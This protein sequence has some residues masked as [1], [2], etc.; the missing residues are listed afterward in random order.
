MDQPKRTP[1]ASGFDLTALL[2]GDL[3][4][5]SAAAVVD[6]PVRDEPSPLGGTTLE[7][8]EACPDASG[9][10]APCIEGTGHTLASH[11]SDVL[12]GS[13]PPAEVDSP[14]D[15][16]QLNAA[17]LQ[18][19][20]QELEDDALDT[21][22]DPDEVEP[23][24]FEIEELV[25][26]LDADDGDQQD[27]EDGLSALVAQLDERPLSVGQLTE[28]LER[29]VLPALRAAAVK[30]GYLTLG[31][32]A[33][34]VVALQASEIH[35]AQVREMVVRLGVPVVP[36]RSHQNVRNLPLAAMHEA[37]RRFGDL[38]QGTP[39]ESLVIARLGYAKVRL[40]EGTRA[41]LMQAWLGHCLSRVEERQHAEAVASEVAR[42]G[43]DFGRW[44]AEAVASREALILDN[45]WSVARIARKYVGRGIEIDDLL[46]FG[47]L[48]LMRAVEKNNPTHGY[49]FVT[50][51]SSWIWQRITREIA[52][53]G[54][55]IRL[56]VHVEEDRKAVEEAFDA[57]Y[58]QL[59][60]PPSI[61]RVAEACGVKQERV[62]ALLVTS[63]P[64][65]L[66]RPG[67]LARIEHRLALAA[68]DIQVDTW[69]RQLAE[70]V[71]QALSS[72]G[73][74]ERKVLE[75][76]FG[77]DIGRDRT[78]EEVGREFGVTRERI[79]QIEA[80]ALRKLHH[81]SRN[82]SLRDYIDLYERPATQQRVGR[83][84][85]PEPTIAALKAALVD[86][87][88]AE[89]E[90]LADVLGLDGRRRRRLKAVC[91]LH[92]VLPEEVDRLQR[93]LRRKVQGVATSS[94]PPAAGTADQGIQKAHAAVT[95]GGR[96]GHR[97]SAAA[98][99]SPPARQGR[100]ETHVQDD[101]VPTD[102]GDLARCSKPDLR[103]R[104][105]IPPAAKVSSDGSAEE[106]SPAPDDTSGLRSLMAKFNPSDAVLADALFGVTTG[107][108]MPAEEV[109]REFGATFAQVRDIEVAAQ[110]LLGAGAVRAR[111][112][113]GAASSSTPTP[114]PPMPT[115]PESTSISTSEPVDAMGAAG[116]LSVEG[117]GEAAEHEGAES[118]DAEPLPAGPD[119]SQGE[120]GS[121]LVSESAMEVIDER[122]APRTLSSAEVWPLVQRFHDR[123]ERQIVEFLFGLLSGKPLTP[124]ATARTLQVPQATVDRVAEAV[125]ILADARA[126]QLQSESIPAPSSRRI[127]PSEVARARELRRRVLARFARHDQR[128][129]LMRYGAAN[130]VPCSVDVVAR[131]LD[132]PVSA[133]QEVSASFEQQLRR[134]GFPSA[135]LPATTDEWDRATWQPS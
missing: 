73:E 123:Q 129:L 77:L 24:D 121:T 16:P 15:I 47:V 19:A 66:D 61:A 68:D 87:T 76:R 128:I 105:A 114:Q 57:L 62:H 134:E 75:L 11:T 93:L 111:E 72:L 120:A 6:A 21:E 92:N 101:H 89:Q 110:Y 26:F 80:K 97:P 60:R 85:L 7:P 33:Y 69:Q 109:V 86:F 10:L 37:Q 118:A 20:P 113:D 95:D 65:S 44:S 99:A 3:P 132:V 5:P 106:N 8:I 43:T 30:P 51:A 78:L 88:A 45:L 96:N 41:F 46:Q 50:Y 23:V 1:P 67:R 39:P 34:A 52:D 119:A 56:P 70:Q 54:R 58:G 84:A 90:I 122:P 48:G 31:K 14:A 13:A 125:Q 126:A 28:R 49:R 9:L 100:P 82:R 53:T 36:S 59:G 112:I 103:A 135:L 63:R 117:G 94:P 83:K 91:R 38:V 130:A 79:R 98:P 74:R 116:P 133:V 22:D 108:P 18:P 127:L 4:S 27:G 17:H 107:K 55:L 64:M 115:A 2:W 71:E 42:V 131:V 29:E 124:D 32:L 102:Q 12:P 25:D 81:P 104:E 40:S 35:L